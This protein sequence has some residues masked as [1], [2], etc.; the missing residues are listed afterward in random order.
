MKQY[1]IPMTRRP[2]QLV[3][4]SCA[5]V[6]AFT[7]PFEVW[8]LCRVL[9]SGDVSVGDE[10]TTSW[11]Q[12]LKKAQDQAAANTFE[13]RILRPVLQLEGEVPANTSPSRIKEV[14]PVL[15][16]HQNNLDLT[17]RAIRTYRDLAR[18]TSRVRAPDAW[19]QKELQPKHP[20]RISL[21]QRVALLDEE[22]KIRNY[23][24][25]YPG[26]QEDG[27]RQARQ[28]VTEY[29]SKLGADLLLVKQARERFAWHELSGR[30]PETE[31]GKTLV[32]LVQQAIQPETDPSPAMLALALEKPIKEVQRHLNSH[33]DAAKKQAEDRLKD[34]R[35]ARQLLSL[36]VHE[37]TSLVSLFQDYEKLYNAS[38]SASM[39]KLIRE[40]AIGKGEKSLERELPLDDLVQLDGVAIP[41]KEVSILWEDNRRETVRLVETE[42][43]ELT[44]PLGQVDRFI[45]RSKTHRRIAPTS[46]TRAH[47]AYNQLRKNLRWTRAEMTQL[48]QIGRQL[49]DPRDRA[50]RSRIE[51]LC[52]ATE[53]APKLFSR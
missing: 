47:A 45:A 35:L 44:L 32:T 25:A 21:E 26:L 17:D 16:E 30:L 11:K 31:T 46:R 19:W 37:P 2:F 27:K 34:Y 15:R 38:S 10:D 1:L 39:Q 4:I 7:L 49:T 36:H 48:R 8:A 18:N 52:N 24:D 23:M 14:L 40:L 20:L 42:Y 3:L 5:V 33:P 6:L 12:Q 9:G 50:L 51:E 41:R 43:N 53:V 13:K 28:S 29:E 22:T